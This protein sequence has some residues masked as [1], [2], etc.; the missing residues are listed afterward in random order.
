MDYKTTETICPKCEGVGI[1]KRKNSFCNQCKTEDFSTV[2]F[3][4]EKIELRNY[5]ECVEC[6]STGKIKSTTLKVPCKT[7]LQAPP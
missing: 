3:V 1:I 4:C 7:H 6:D 5:K 2:C